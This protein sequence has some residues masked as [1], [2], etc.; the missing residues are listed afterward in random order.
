M[1]KLEETFRKCLGWFVRELMQNKLA[2]TEKYP[3]HKVSPLEQKRENSRETKEMQMK[4]M[5]IGTY[6]SE[7]FLVQT[8]GP[9]RPCLQ[10][11]RC[12]LYCRLHQ[13]LDQARQ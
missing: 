8:T 4:S 12:Q 10:R 5:N 2:S 1:E 9:R 7:V 6:S 13:R 3:I 11:Y